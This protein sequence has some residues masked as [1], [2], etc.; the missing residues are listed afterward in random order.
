MPSD[1]P[2]AEPDDRIE[3]T[4]IRP[5]P[6]GRARRAGAAGTGRRRRP[7]VA[8]PPRP[9]RS[10][11]GGRRE[12]VRVGSTPLLA[13][14][15]P[16]LQLLAR[17]RNT[18][19][20]PDPGR[21]AGARGARG[22]P[23]E[24]GR[25][26]RGVPIDQLRPA[27]YA[28]CASLDDVVLAT[29]WGSQGAWA[30]RSLVSTFHQEVRSGERFFDVL[31]QVKQ[32]PGH[33]PAGDR[34]DVPVPVARL[35]GPLPAVAARP[36]GARPDARGDLRRH[37]P[38]AAEAGSRIVAALAGRD[39]RRTGPLARGTAGLGCRGGRA[40]GDRGTVTPGPRSG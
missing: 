40:G 13:A 16:L 9:R 14:A 10:L 23:F 1:N 27:H 15:A 4:I 8:A 5:T 24:Q 25:A 19:S 21:P 7:P 22:A 36:G 37:R 34:A 30:S 6:G 38:T 31:N 11:A 39:A 18:L 2:F 3:R 32:N 12:A 20:Q 26:T 17:L 35:S 33:V 28:L 29:P